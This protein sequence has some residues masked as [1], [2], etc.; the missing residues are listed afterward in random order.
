MLTGVRLGLPQRALPTVS[1]AQAQ[2]QAASTGAGQSNRGWM[3]EIVGAKSTE[4]PQDSASTSTG[5]DGQSGTF[6]LA[7]FPIGSKVIVL[8]PTEN[9]RPCIVVAH[10]DAEEEGGEESD[11]AIQVHYE[12]FDD[13]QTRPNRPRADKTRHFGLRRPETFL[14]LL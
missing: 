4:P 10:E 12:M 6:T 7:D 3:N 13:D 8:S 9:W 5:A 14:Y 11:A 1:V 2:K